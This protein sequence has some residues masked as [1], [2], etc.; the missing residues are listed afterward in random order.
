M[1]MYENWVHRNA[2]TMGRRILFL[3]GDLLENCAPQ[4]PI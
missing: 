2:V 1:P 3:L 4:C